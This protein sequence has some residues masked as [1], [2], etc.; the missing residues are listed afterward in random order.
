M[1]ARI[2]MLAVIL[3][4]PVLPGCYTQLCAPGTT[5]QEP[6]PA[7][8]SEEDAP[9]LLPGLDTCRFPRYY[10]PWERLFYDPYGDRWGTGSRFY[11]SY[12]TFR[13]FP[14]RL[15]SGL[16]FY[17][18]WSMG[19][20]AAGLYPDFWPDFWRRL[21]PVFHRVPDSV[22][23]AAPRPR[24]R[25]AGFGTEIP[26][27]L[28]IRAPGVTTRAAGSG[29]AGPIVEEPRGQQGHTISSPSPP[30]PK[31]TVMPPKQ[32]AKKKEEES[33]QE[34]RDEKRKEGRRREGMK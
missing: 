18:A 31:K 4:L 34:K 33:K 17:D 11:Y 8:P 3:L 9:T 28:E 10:D 2:L 15:G 12:D 30:P 16:L 13:S 29:Q 21:S 25:R 1:S 6:L 20:P 32:D 22:R 14:W 27:A 26:S 23:L 5:G 24:I 19:Y 7:H